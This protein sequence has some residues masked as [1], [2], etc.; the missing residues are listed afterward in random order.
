MKFKKPKFWDLSKPNFISFFLLPFTIAVIINNF[1]LNKKV[2]QSYNKIKTICVG[3]IYLGGTGKTPTTI[4]LFNILKVLNLNIF[5]AKK[6]YKSQIDEIVILENKTKLISAK[7]RT[8]IIK[9]SIEKEC[10]LLIFDD[11]LQDKNISYDLEFVCFDAQNLIGNGLLIPAG[12]LREKINSLKKYDGIFLKND[13]DDDVSNFKKL[14]K[15]INPNIKIFHTYF[16]IKNLEKFN[17]SEKYLIFSGIGNPK[18]F[19]KAL[20]KNNFNVIDEIVFPDHFNYNKGIIGKIKERAK[21]NNAK[22]IT[23]EKDFVK[24]SKFDEDDIAFLEIELK[25]ENEE[26]LLNF[27]KTKIYEKI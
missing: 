15:K 18:N 7:S 13:N 12:P 3:N 21:K 10:D 5:T 16:E 4:K 9:K 8:K 14:V 24:I 23:T 25:I 6:L 1:L 11:G 17:L 22:I 2:K 20:L 26:D 27:I 19:K